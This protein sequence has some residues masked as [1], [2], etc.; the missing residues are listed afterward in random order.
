MNF[1]TD[2]IMFLFLFILPGAFSKVLLYKFA[3]KKHNDCDGKT[4]TME[5]SEV[6]VFSALIFVI[7]MIIMWIHNGGFSAVNI[8]SKMQN[9]AFLLRYIVLTMMVTTICT[10]LQHFGVSLLFNKCINLYNGVR[11]KP[12]ELKFPTIWENIFESKQILDLAGQ[13]CVV[14]IEKSGVVISSGKLQYYP[15]PHTKCNELGLIYCAEIE[16]YFERDRK[17]TKD[18]YKIF[19]ETILEYYNMEYDVLIK[20][21]DMQKFNEIQKQSISAEEAEQEEN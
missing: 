7:N 18:E 15:A 16:A 20:F 3:P 11:L 21:Y 10:G 14:A 17:C 4:A 1:S 12:Q 8:I 13:D 6:I 9:E 5:L 19:H 2:S